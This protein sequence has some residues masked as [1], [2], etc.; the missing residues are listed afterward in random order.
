VCAVFEALCSVFDGHYTKS[1]NCFVS[2]E[3]KGRHALITRV[4]YLRKR[5]THDMG[6]HLLSLEKGDV[7]YGGASPFYLTT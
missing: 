1:G 2:G 7:R 6:V 4:F 5:E 3:E